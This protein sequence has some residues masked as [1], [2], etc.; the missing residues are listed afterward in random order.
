MMEE[1]LHSD[2]VYLRPEA[3]PLSWLTQP[4]R[5][6]RYARPRMLYINVAITR[7]SQDI[8]P[9]AIRIRN[10]SLPSSH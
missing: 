10:R 5:Y 8:K 6:V 7:L 1:T 3:S 2:Q 9:S 4:S